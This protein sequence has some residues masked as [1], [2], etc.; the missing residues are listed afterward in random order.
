MGSV[1]PQQQY[2]D[3]RVLD[4]SRYDRILTN[5][6]TGLCLCA[7]RTDSAFEGSH[8]SYPQTVP[9]TS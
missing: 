2:D 7:V 8:S 6:L 4:A 1:T 5:Y 9:M 3:A